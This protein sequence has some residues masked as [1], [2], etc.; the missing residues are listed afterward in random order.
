MSRWLTARPRVTAVGT[1]PTATLSFHGRMRLPLPC[2]Q[3]QV[4]GRELGKGEEGLMARRRGPP[5]P[6]WHTGAHVVA[7]MGRRGQVGFRGRE[8][9][10]PP[11]WTQL[12]LFILPL[13][14]ARHDL[15][16]GLF[17]LPVSQRSPLTPQEG[18]PFPLGSGTA[19]DQC[20]R[21]TSPQL[22]LNS[23]WPSKKDAGGE[24]K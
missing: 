19:H 3:K 5:S 11:P 15:Q 10:A 9:R 17:F 22:K 14:T 16:L 7:Q 23:W 1:W 24:P 21:S 4:E 12:S 6:S 18:F 2:Q 20:T 13:N 8:G